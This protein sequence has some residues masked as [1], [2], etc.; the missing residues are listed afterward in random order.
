MSSTR[1]PSTI[2]TGKSIDSRPLILMFGDLLEIKSPR[3]HSI[4]LLVFGVPTVAP[5]IIRY[6]A[7]R[8]KSWVFLLTFGLARAFSRCV[9]LGLSRLQSS[10]YRSR[11]RQHGSHSKTVGH[12]LRLRNCDITSKSSIACGRLLTADGCLCRVTQAKLSRSV[13]IPEEIK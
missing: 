10:K 3:V 7:T 13:S 2:P 12:C 8:E 5:V 6:V 11:D 9:R 4:K 1:L